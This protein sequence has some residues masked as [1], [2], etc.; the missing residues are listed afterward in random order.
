MAEKTASSAGSIIIP[1]LNILHFPFAISQ[2]KN[3]FFCNKFFRE[4]R[5]LQKQNS[6]YRIVYYLNFKYSALSIRNFTNFF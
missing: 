6:L 1:I 3:I 5:I 4:I 2:K